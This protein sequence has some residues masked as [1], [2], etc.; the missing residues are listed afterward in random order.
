MSYGVILSLI[1]CC[2][3]SD[4]RVTKTHSL[5]N[6]FTIAI[7]AYKEINGRY[8]ISESGKSWLYYAI[9]ENTDKEIKEYL[10]S[11]YSYMLKSRLRNGIEA[12]PVDIYLVDYWGNE[13]IYKITASDKYILY[14]R[15]INAIDEDGEGDDISNIFGLTSY[16]RELSLKHIMWIILGLIIIAALLLF[17]YYKKLNL[18]PKI[19]PPVIRE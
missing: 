1:V 7:E 15:G 3:I 16:R 13:I 17:I 19:S 12:Q 18:P 8:P 10:L 5:I 2:Q 11:E 9:F 6:S 14:S 4:W